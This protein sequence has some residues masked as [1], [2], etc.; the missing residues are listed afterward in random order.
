MSEVM[1]KKLIIVTGPTASGK[2]DVA[3]ELALRLGGMIVSAD[4]VQVYRGM[5][6]GSAKI[7]ESEMR[8]V[9]HFLIDA[10]APDESF[11]VSAFVSL[12]REAMDS[13]Y[14]AGAVPIIAGGTA[15][16]IQ[17]LL[18]GVEF[19][20]D[21]GA[22]EVFRKEAEGLLAASDDSDRKAFF[23]KYF[24]G[25]E[26][27]SGVDFSLPSDDFLY[28]LLGRVDPE[29]CE[30]IHKNNHK[31]M[32]RALEYF[33]A[34]GEA[35]SEYNKREACKE[36]EYDYSYFVLTDSRERLYERINKRVDGMVEAGLEDEVRRLRDEGY[37][38]ALPSMQS[39]GYKEMFSYIEGEC[40]FERAV[41]EIKKNTRHFAKRQLTWFRRERDVIEVDVE[42]CSYNAGR[43]AD[44]IMERVS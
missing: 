5:D 36:S 22:D 2:S 27:C 10:L 21:T 33:K 16:Y 30:S 29:Y 38:R 41:E 40:S 3:V 18:K 23:L 25:F 42:A 43:V 35:F 1:K 11:N 12:A 34:T 6:I 26:K 4:S 9:K 28:E 44:V 13:V 15:F 20:E 19:S 17:A 7:T 31:R 37:S 14:A 32:I 8:G 24:A 39:I